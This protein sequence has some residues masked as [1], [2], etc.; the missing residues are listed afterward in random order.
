MD[1][2]DWLFLLGIF[3]SFAVSVWSLVLNYISTRQTRFIN[4]ITSQRIQW[5]EQL[6]QDIAAFAGLTYTWSVS[7]MDGKPQGYEIVREVDKLRYLIRLRLNP[8]GKNDREIERLMDEVIS[9]TDPSQGADLNKLL[10]ELTHK[11]QLLLKV[12][13]EKIKLESISGKL[14]QD[15]YGE[16]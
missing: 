16:R 14:K 12:E 7:A 2:K 6:R 11:T 9:R 8:N 10:R 4:T 3:V 13:W 15:V 5:L 1:T